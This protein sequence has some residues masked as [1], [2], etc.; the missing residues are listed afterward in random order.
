[1]K[2]GVYSF[3]CQPR[4]FTYAGRI[5]MGYRKIWICSNILVAGSDRFGRGS[6]VNYID[7]YGWRSEVQQNWIP[8]PFYGSH[9]PIFSLSARDDITVQ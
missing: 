3:W 9:R 2:K 7:S 5:D 8:Q 4:Y 1:M 6:Q